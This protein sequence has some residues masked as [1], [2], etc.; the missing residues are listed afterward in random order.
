MRKSTSP[1]ILIDRFPRLLHRFFAPR[2]GLESNR[3]EGDVIHAYAQARGELVSELDG[4][5]EAEFVFSS[6]LC[7]IAGL[8][9][10]AFHEMVRS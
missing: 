7:H 8:N 9:E 10:E 1:R 4:H 3:I 6:S 2:G 5:S